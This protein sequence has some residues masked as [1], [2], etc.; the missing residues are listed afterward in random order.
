MPAVTFSA[1]QLGKHCYTQ[2]PLT[3]DVQEARALAEMAERQRVVTQ[4]GIQ[5]HS[6]VRLK[7]AVATVQKGV[8]GKVREVHTWTDRPGS[9]WQQGRARPD[10]VDPVPPQLDWDL[11]LG[12]APQ[13]PFAAG[14]YYHP[15]HWR[16]VVGFW[17]RRAG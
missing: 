1:L 2:K 12:T 7:R 3:H 13:R 9:F 5:H 4:M 8:I 14:D 15:F 6:S 16:G 17:H 10:R 11:W